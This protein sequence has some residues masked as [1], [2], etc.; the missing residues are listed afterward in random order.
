MSNKRCVIIGGGYSIKEGIK[1]GLW[2]NIKNEEIW[3]TNYSFLVLPFLPKCQLWSDFT[4]F[5]GCEKEVLEL[6]KKGVELIARSLGTVYYNFPVTTYETT[7]K[8]E[9]ENKIFVGQLGLVGMFALGVAIKRGYKKIFLLGYD[10]GT[11]KGQESKK[12]YYQEKEEKPI[13]LVYRNENGIIKDCVKDFD[14]YKD[15]ADIYNVSL[16]SNINSFE[17]ISWEEFFRKIKG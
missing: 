12:W 7:N 10:F 17:K 2:G 3:S 5:L 8:K 13:D 1:K 4:F 15:K 16:I 14:E 6:G 11:P 9:E